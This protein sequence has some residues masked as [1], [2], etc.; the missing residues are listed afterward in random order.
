VAAAFKM[1]AG[2]IYVSVATAEIR[3]PNTHGVRPDLSALSATGPYCV[4]CDIFGG[5]KA[6]R[7]GSCRRANVK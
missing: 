7:S 1:R 4:G 6:G 5:G 2:A 3:H